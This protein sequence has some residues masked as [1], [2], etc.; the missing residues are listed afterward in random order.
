MDY[1]DNYI[2]MV[3]MAE[4]GL[5]TAIRTSIQDFSIK[6]ID[7]FSYNDKIFGLLHGQ[8][9]S[10][11]TAQA[12]GIIAQASNKGFSIFL[13]L[14]TDNISL[15]QQTLDRARQ[16]L[17]F[18][19]V[20]DE[21]EDSIFYKATASKPIIV[22]LKKN[23][24]VLSSWL[25][26]FRKSATMK[27]TPLMIIDDEG[28]AASLN[29]KVNKSEQSIINSL[30]K[31]I[32]QIPPS[33]IYLQV[34]AT[35]QSL[36]LQSRS[37]GWKPAF[38][39]SFNPGKQYKGGKDFYGENSQLQKIIEDNEV[40][41][42]LSSPVIPE[43]LKKAFLQFLV[44][45]IQIELLGKPVCNMLIHPSHKISDH[46]KVRIK[47]QNLISDLK[48]DLLSQSPALRDQVYY[49]WSD[50]KQ[51]YSDIAPFEEVWNGFGKA[52][53]NTRIIV[54]N[55]NKER[56]GSY[57]R[58]TAVLI[59]GNVLGR[60]LTIPGLQTVYYTRLSKTPLA[61]TVL[62]HQRIFGYDRTL[63]LCR[64]FATKQLFKI[65][66]D[67]TESSQI[68]FDL[69]L[70][71]PIEKISIM[72]P[73]NIKA[74]RRNV[75]KLSDVPLIAGGVNYFP[76]DPVDTNTKKLDRRL[77]LSRSDTIISLAEA[78]EILEMQEVENSIDWNKD[79]FVA[80]VKALISKKPDVK[81]LLIVRTERSITKGTGSLLSPDD[82]K[83]GDANPDKLVLTMYRLK[84]EVEQ[85]WNGRPIWVPNI[86]LPS[87]N[88]FW[89]NIDG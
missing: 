24:R 50:L 18:F 61:D 66:R 11:K 71:E 57:N 48:I 16:F 69:V 51:T 30:L 7:T 88:V 6:H 89:K 85:Y 45:G 43:S 3:D 74:T 87:G 41:T 47:M 19:Q 84:G 10:G 55:S 68:L 26:N 70:K 4:S 2:K 23:Q 54:L 75:I 1:F 22:I 49:A 20:C 82:R 76:Y 46:E 64:V 13:Y 83:L 14:T 12:L 17:P 42:L 27:S 9:Q 28:D 40:N 58:G 38:A 86:K 36:L 53:T 25:A 37:S 33:G 44:A 15:Q 73:G 59:G 52:L 31:N 5:G 79:A 34:T 72:L 77:G 60:G 29:T 39:Y 78:V 35:P 63:E 21:N 81:C 67:L 62:Q 56:N 65:F 8:V 32:F 80:S